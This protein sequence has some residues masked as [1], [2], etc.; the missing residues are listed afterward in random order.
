MTSY[1]KKAPLIEAL[2]WI[3]NHRD[4]FLFL[5][6]KEEDYSEGVGVNFRIDKRKDEGGLIIQT[7]AGEE[8]VKLMHFVIKGE[9]GEL[10]TCPY[11]E[12]MQTY[13]RA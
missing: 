6:G 9:N 12:F 11:E 13:E 8:V 10:H 5:G 4:M 7:A 1:R 3:R 2:P